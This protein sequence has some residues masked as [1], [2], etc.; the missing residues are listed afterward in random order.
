MEKLATSVKDFVSMGERQ[1]P[2]VEMLLKNRQ[3]MEEK[4]TGYPA[5]KDEHFIILGYNSDERGEYMKKYKVKSLKL[6]D[7]VISQIARLLQV[8]ILT[9]TDIVDNL[10][11]LRLTV[12]GELLHPD[13]EYSEHFDEN[14]NRLLEE[15]HNLSG[16]DN[17][18]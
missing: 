9:G 13:S 6:S 10:R 12:D 18:R 14:L 17:A 16:E 2:W 5:Y 11:M 8:A 3:K 4:H 15:A 1:I 7:P